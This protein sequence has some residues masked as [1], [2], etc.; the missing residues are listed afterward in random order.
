MAFLQGAQFIYMGQAPTA[1]KFESLLSPMQ[2]G[3]D[4]RQS[5]R[6]DVC[7]SSQCPHAVLRLAQFSVDI[8]QNGVNGKKCK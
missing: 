5:S 7:R 6:K 4:R 2:Q 3:P 8:K 1:T